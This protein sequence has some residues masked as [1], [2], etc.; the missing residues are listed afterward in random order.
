MTR[1][2][3]FGRVMLASVFLASVPA[4][5]AFAGKGGGP[6]ANQTGNHNNQSVSKN[7]NRNRQ[8]TNSTNTSTNV[9]ANI[10]I[11][12]IVIGPPR[13]SSLSQC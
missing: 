9:N 11:G 8:E 10:D 7:K 6:R 5:S 1:F 3:L 4:T 12:V 2:S 13:C